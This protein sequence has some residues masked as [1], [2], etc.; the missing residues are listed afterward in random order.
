MF[1]AFGA[2]EKIQCFWLKNFKI[3]FSTETIAFLSFFQSRK[4]GVPLKAKYFSFRS[5]MLGA[6]LCQWRRRPVGALFVFDEAFNENARAANKIKVS[7][8]S[9]FLTTKHDFGVRLVGKR[10]K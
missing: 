5:K 3:I 8:F 7:Q 2:R 9:A 4:L 10:Q 1:E 6:C